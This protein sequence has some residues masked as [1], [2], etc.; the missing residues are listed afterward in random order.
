MPKKGTKLTREQR[1]LMQVASGMTGGTGISPKL[2]R[3]IE[4]R[5]CYITGN[6][7]GLPMDALFAGAANRLIYPRNFRHSM[8]WFCLNNRSR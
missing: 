2:T 5:P 6:G 1:T 4:I 8:G 7:E 3:E